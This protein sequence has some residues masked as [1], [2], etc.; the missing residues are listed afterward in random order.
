MQWRMSDEGQKV[1]AQ[2]QRRAIDSVNEP[3]II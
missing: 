1:F 2:R 3:V